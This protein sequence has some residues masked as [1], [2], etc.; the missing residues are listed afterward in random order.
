MHHYLEEPQG[1]FF[2][3]QAHKLQMDALM[4]QVLKKS[5]HVAFSHYRIICSMKFLYETV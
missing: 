4:V 2:Y 3:G 1:F 5:L